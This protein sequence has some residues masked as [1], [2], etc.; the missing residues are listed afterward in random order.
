MCVE[1][2]VK[3]SYLLYD[4][5]YNIST[6]KH[7]SHVCIFIEYFHLLSSFHYFIFKHTASHGVIRF[8][9]NKN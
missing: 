8:A 6:L 7:V 1:L 9:K 3:Y 4:S 5:V 2:S